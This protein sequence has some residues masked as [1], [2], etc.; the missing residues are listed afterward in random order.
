MI[1]RFGLPLAA[2]TAVGL[3]SSLDA[4]PAWA[5]DAED[6]GAIRL[7]P[8]T[9][10]ANKREQSLDRVDGAVAVRTAEDLEA[11][12]VTTV[13][14]LEKVFPGLE[15]RSNCCVARRARCTA[16]MPTVA[17]S[18]SSP[19]SPTACESMAAA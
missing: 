17:S 7:A 10:T 15:I 5:R 4:A 14:D 1:R 19:A 11:A 12:G 8:V 18:T 6:D 16:A 2:V 3:M 13:Q 9:V